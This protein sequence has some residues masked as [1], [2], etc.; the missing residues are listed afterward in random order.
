M[1]TDMKIEFKK[2]TIYMS[3]SVRGD[4]SRTIE[5]NCD[6][7]CRVAEKIRRTFP[8][9]GIYC[10]AEHDH[11]LQI[12]WK[13]KK[14]S[15]KD[16]MYA[17]LEILKSCH[18]WFWWF[19]GDSDGCREEM[20]EAVSLFSWGLGFSRVIESD[21]LKANYSDCRRVLGPVVKAAK[22]NFQNS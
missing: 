9:I 17:D 20:S 8:E 5:E 1:A 4:G 16:I 18:E 14:V 19:T 10:P 11:A 22:K 2:P 7:A 6:R 12:L 21:L 13:A 15:I 3:H